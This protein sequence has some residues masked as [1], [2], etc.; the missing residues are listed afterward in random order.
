MSVV[1]NV[2]FSFHISDDHIMEKINSWLQE[3]DY[4]VFSNVD[5]VSGGRKHLET[6]LFAAAF[7]YFN[8]ENFCNFVRSLK[9]KHPNCVQIFIQE[10]EDDKFRLIEPCAG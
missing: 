3:N 8:L 9:W 5:I 10:Q 1:S 4:G 6:P 2:V 7:N